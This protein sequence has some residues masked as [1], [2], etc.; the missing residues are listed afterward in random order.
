M[1]AAEHV[2]VPEAA[3]LMLDNAPKAHR[4]GEQDHGDDHKADGDFI[5]DH[6][7]RRPQTAKEGVFRVGGPAAH[8]DAVHTKGGNGEEVEDA[9]IDIGDHPARGEGDHRPAHQGQGEG[10]DRR[11]KEDE[12]VG[13]VRNDD[14]LQDELEQVGKGLKQAKRTHH[15]GPLAH[16]DPGPD[17][18]VGQHEEGQGDQQGQDHQHDLPKGD[19]GPSE[20]VA[21]KVFAPMALLRRDL[22]GSPKPGRRTRP[23][24]R[25]R[26][27]QGSSDG[28]P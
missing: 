20:G 12:L 27:R 23:S 22:G 25:S 4:A 3:P 16:L 8:D 7:G 5:A 14:F 18:A 13:S 10:Q 9:H 2:P 1:A 17:L 21:Q 28:R 26:G 15:I 24:S 11:Q 6:L 19:Q